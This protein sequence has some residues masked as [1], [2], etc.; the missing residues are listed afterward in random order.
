MKIPTLEKEL[1]RSIIEENNETGY[2]HFLRWQTGTDFKGEL[3]LSSS[4]FL[5]Y[6]YKRYSLE[7]KTNPQLQLFEGIYKKNILI[8]SL[9]LEIVKQFSNLLKQEEIEHAFMGSLALSK[10][11]NWEPYIRKLNAIECLIASN[12]AK[13]CVTILKELKYE[14]NERKPGKKINQLSFSKVN[15]PKIIIYLWPVT[16]HNRKISSEYFLQ[17]KEIDP[18]NHL[19][20]EGVFLQSILNLPFQNHWYILIDCLLVQTK[21][22]INPNIAKPYFDMA[23]TWER[24]QELLDGIEITKLKEF[25][26]SNKIEKNNYTFGN[27]F[28]KNEQDFNFKTVAGKIAMQANLAGVLHKNI[29]NPSNWLKILISW[30]DKRS[31]L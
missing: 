2:K 17:K 11:L 1:I 21:H 12:Q 25:I 23:G 13:K 18:I 5:P 10:T 26:I 4:L 31:L 16:F 27:Y 22:K 30:I 20:A 3:S 7:L 9:G 24:Y 19:N 6:L 14:L 29:F 15:A 28:L 8:N